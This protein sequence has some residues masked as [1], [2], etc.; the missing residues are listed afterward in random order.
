MLIFFFLLHRFTA[1][2]DT[3]VTADKN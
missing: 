3:F 2:V 1:T